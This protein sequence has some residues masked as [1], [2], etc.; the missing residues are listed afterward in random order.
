MI[1]YPTKDEVSRFVLNTH[2]VE[3]LKVKN[4]DITDIY[5]GQSKNPYVYG[6]FDGLSYALKILLGSPDFPCKDITLIQNSYR[7]YDALYWLRNLH[8]IITLPLAKASEQDELAIEFTVNRAS[9]GVYRTE[10]LSLAFT[11]APS[12]RLIPCLLHNWLLSI[13]T[14][15]DQIKDKVDNPYAL[16]RED[17][18]KMNTLSSESCLLMAALQPFDVASNRLGRLIE[19]LLRL[20]WRLPWKTC[21]TNHQDREYKNWI[22]ELTDFQR[23]KLPQLITNAEVISKKWGI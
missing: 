7:S 2:V 10:E 12:P 6:M 15:H 4:Q 17:A 20:T 16:S 23:S 3:Q 1:H 11:L 21:P 8:S 5:S 19:N 13:S 22:Q 9:V 18:H 14:F